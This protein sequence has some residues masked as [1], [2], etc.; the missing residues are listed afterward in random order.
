[1]I[2]NRFRNAQIGRTLTMALLLFCDRKQTRHGKSHDDKRKKGGVEFSLENEC[3]T[4]QKHNQKQR[5]ALNESENNKEISN[6][7]GAATNLGPTNFNEENIKNLN[8]NKFGELN[9][10]HYLKVLRHFDAEFQASKSAL[11]E[12]ESAN[13]Y[14]E[15]STK[16]RNKKLSY[17]QAFSRQIKLTQMLGRDPILSINPTDGPLRW[18]P[19]VDIYL[20]DKAGNNSLFPMII[21]TDLYANLQTS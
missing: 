21:M 15:Q 14:E 3:I 19:N 6:T 2:L 10:G 16:K 8:T 20:N 7:N 9:R 18:E 12:L 5:S 4:N 11:I 17:R 13:I 1:M